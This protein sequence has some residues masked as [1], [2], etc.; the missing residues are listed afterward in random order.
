METQNALE[1]VSY[2][3]GLK[4]GEEAL[5]DPVLLPDI[6]NQAIKDKAN[7]DQKSIGLRDYMTATKVVQTLRLEHQKQQG[8]DWL[9]EIGQEEGVTTTASGLRYKVIKEGSGQKCWAG[10][11]AKVHYE[12]KL[13]DGTVFDSSYTN[14]QPASFPVRAVIKGWQEGLE[15]MTVGSHYQFYIPQELAYGERGAGSDIPPYSALFFEVE[16]LAAF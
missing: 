14:G 3:L 12:G 4:L 9:T 15:L 1:I 2:K 13:Q 10:A 6:I 8:Y 5:K 7:C 16:L 11:T